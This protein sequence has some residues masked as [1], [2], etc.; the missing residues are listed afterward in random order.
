MVICS[1]CK[2][3]SFLLFYFYSPL[4]PE[5]T[6]ITSL[7]CILYPQSLR[8]PH[9]SRLLG[10]VSMFCQICLE[11]EWVEVRGRERYGDKGWTYGWRG[12]KAVWLMGSKP[13]I[14]ARKVH[15]GAQPEYLSPLELILIIIP[16][17]LMPLQSLRV[18]G[19]TKT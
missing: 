7:F 18:H 12:N 5:N 19:E 10:V 17:H 15:L 6:E 13:V 16:T 8:P 2:V 1:S 4:H 9:F 11:V 3:L 14:A